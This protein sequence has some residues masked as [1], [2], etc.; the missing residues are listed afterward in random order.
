MTVFRCSSCTLVF[1]WPQLSEESIHELYDQS[2]YDSWGI[3]QDESVRDM[4]KLTFKLRLKDIERVIAPGR[5]LDVGC[6]TG[7]FLEAAIERGWDAYGIEIN[8]YAVERA[9]EHLGERVVRGTIED[10]LFEPSFFDAI[11]MSDVLEH[12][13]GPLATLARVRELLRPGGVVAITTPN[14]AS[15]TA[16]LLRSRWPHV[17]AEHQFYF[18]PRSLTHLLDMAGFRLLHLRPAAKALTLNYIYAQRNVS[19]VPILTPL[20]VSLLKFLPDSLRRRPLYFLAGELF[21]I[22]RKDAT[23]DRARTA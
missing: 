19:K 20:V 2:Y 22:A 21:A 1:A 4:K 5:V 23:S 16:R 11:T 9:H 6:A 18:S 15:I 3:Q 12:V 8:P 17:K 14:I 10:A 7:Y 13:R